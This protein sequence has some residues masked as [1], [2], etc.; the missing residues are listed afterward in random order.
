MNR[1]DAPVAR[2]TVSSARGLTRHPREGLDA[3]WTL[4]ERIEV[5]P[6]DAHAEV[7]VV[8][9]GFLSDMPV[10][11]ELGGYLDPIILALEDAIG[12]GRLRVAVEVVAM[13]VR[14][15][16]TGTSRNVR[17]AFASLVSDGCLII[18]SAGVTDNA[19]VLRTEIEAAC[20]PY[21]TM[22]GTTR[23]VGEYCFSLANG[24]HGEEAAILASFLADQGH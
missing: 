23:F 19:L 3:T 10:G 5:R 2:C 22:A 13:H 24:G 4:A 15:L 11:D 9:V 1:D 16:P 8:R 18:G 7:A 14:G 12:E 21:V 6:A 17:D 20:V